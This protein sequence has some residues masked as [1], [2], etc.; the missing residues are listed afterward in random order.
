MAHHCPSLR[1]VLCIWR[2]RRALHCLMPHCLHV[3]IG[4]LRGLLDLWSLWSRHWS[5]LLTR[6]LRGRRA[7]LLQG[8]G[9]SEQVVVARCIRWRTARRR[10]RR[11]VCPRP[12]LWRREEPPN[13]AH[14]DRPIPE[15]VPRDREGRP[16][17]Q[18]MRDGL[19]ELPG[20]WHAIDGPCPVFGM[21]N[22]S[23]AF[24]TAA[25]TRFERFGWSRS[26]AQSVM[27]F[28]MILFAAARPM[29]PDCA[30]RMRSMADFRSSSTTSMIS[31]QRS[32]A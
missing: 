6:A 23:R 18:V 31:S 32:A 5:I 2:D 30:R 16:V 27:R 11:G 22:R 21:S 25:V 20:P 19:E 9:A 17:L 24:L 7:L 15:L 3:H 8:H 29:A 4:A 1:N 12:A 14:L 13:R 10:T 26:R 28:H